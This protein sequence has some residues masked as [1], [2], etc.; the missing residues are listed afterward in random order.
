M[1]QKTEEG[2]RRCA[3]GLWS[4]ETADV[5]VLCAFGSN[6]GWQ[7]GGRGAGEPEGGAAQR[8]L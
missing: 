3:T 2:W 5:T 1:R 6:P 4:V 7:R 8:T